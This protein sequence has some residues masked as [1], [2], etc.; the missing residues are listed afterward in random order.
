MTHQR[1]NS[2]AKMRRCGAEMRRGDPRD[3]A[4]DIETATRFLLASY[5]R[6]EEGASSGVACQERRRVP[7]SVAINRFT[8]I[9]A[10]LGL[11]WFFRPT[12]VRSGRL[13]AVTVRRTRPWL[14]AVQASSLTG[15]RNISKRRRDGKASIRV[16]RQRNIKVV[17]LRF[18][19]VVHATVG[20]CAGN[21]R[22]P[23]GQVRERRSGAEPRSRS[24]RSRAA[25]HLP[26]RCQ[27]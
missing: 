22:R 19:R 26:G 3:C 20:I 12:W 4:G 10:G 7:L 18:V 23:A 25:T 14:R 1:R 2:D 13:H 21:G 27:R 15:H 6:G 24:R 11:V 8:R 17:A 9:P 16:R 5:R